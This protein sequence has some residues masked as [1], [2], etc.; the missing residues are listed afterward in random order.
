M[1]AVVR[2]EKGKAV[3]DFKGIPVDQ[4]ELLAEALLVK[5]PVS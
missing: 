5:P 2:N 3:M 4:L 1:K